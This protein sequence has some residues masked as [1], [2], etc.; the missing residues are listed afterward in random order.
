MELINAIKKPEMRK[1]FGERYLEII[2][3]QLLGIRLTPSE[4]TRLSRD[5]KKKFMVIQLLSGFASEALKKGAEIKRKIEKIKAEIISS[6]Y[7]PRI[8][9][10]ILYGSSV[11]GIRTFRSDIDIAVEFDDIGLKEATKFRIKFNQDKN[12]DVQVYNILPE[13]IKNEINEK[14]KIIYERKN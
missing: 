8:K 10:I 13:K 5:I 14:G 7:F 3:K 1:I 4:R 11:Y 9:K 6:E 2:E 12:V